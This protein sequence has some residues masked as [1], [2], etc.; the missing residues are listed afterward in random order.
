[1]YVVSRWMMDKNIRMYYIIRRK[2]ILCVC[3]YV[4]LWEGH[5]Q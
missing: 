5:E 3:T 4:Y 2:L 1:M